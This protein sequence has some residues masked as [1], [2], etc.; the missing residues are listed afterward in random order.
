MSDLDLSPAFEKSGK[1]ARS[2]GTTRR[3]AETDSDSA[4]AVN[5][6]GTDST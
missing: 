2:G 4:G 6:T 1:I 5:D 3:V